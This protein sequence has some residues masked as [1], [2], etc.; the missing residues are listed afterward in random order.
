MCR[1]NENRTDGEAFTY[2][3]A[4]NFIFSIGML[5]NDLSKERMLYKSPKGRIIGRSE[6][7]GK[8]NAQILQNPMSD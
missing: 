4:G 7:C 2:E 6:L 1:A 8:L 3:M 5:I